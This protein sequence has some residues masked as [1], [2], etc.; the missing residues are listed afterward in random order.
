MCSLL[1]V[2]IQ[3]S[4]RCPW[5]FLSQV[6]KIEPERLN[7]YA[8]AAATGHLGDLKRGHFSV[9]MTVIAPDGSECEKQ[10]D[11]CDLRESLHMFM[12]KSSV[13]LCSVTDAD[14]VS[15]I[16]LSWQ[17]SAGGPLD[18]EAVALWRKDEEDTNEP[19]K[20]SSK[21]FVDTIL[22]VELVARGGKLKAELLSS[23]VRIP[24]LSPPSSSP[25]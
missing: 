4:P 14:S 10:L 5:C 22:P 3:R 17:G 15:G 23:E 9:V 25:S 13:E 6:A 16:L 12:R 8:D 1:H 20:P 2:F 11:S 18:W 7:L 24:A 21:E 19:W